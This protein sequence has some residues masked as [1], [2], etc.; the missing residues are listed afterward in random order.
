MILYFVKEYLSEKELPREMID[1]NL[2][3]YY[4]QLKQV[5][6]TDGRPNGNFTI[7][8]RLISGETISIS[9][10]IQ[11]SSSLDITKENNFKSFMFYL[12]L[13]SIKDRDFD[14]NLKIPNEAVKRIL[15]SLITVGITSI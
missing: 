2:K 14:L 12:G 13:V 11:D 1:I 3:S 7:I 8:L 10:L 5:I 9:N 15:C 4:S 6:Y